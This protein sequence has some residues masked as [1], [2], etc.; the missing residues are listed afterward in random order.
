MKKMKYAIERCIRLTRRQT[1]PKN[2]AYHRL[3]IRY[4]IAKSF[5]VPLEIDRITIPPK[6]HVLQ[7]MQT[8]E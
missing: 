7:D 1:V 3:S 4:Q 6:S 5:N 2:I 8:G